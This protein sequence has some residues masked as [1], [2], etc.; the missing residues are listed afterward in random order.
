MRI[1]HG[2][3]LAQSNVSGRVGEADRGAP[4]WFHNQQWG[5]ERQWQ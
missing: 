2:Y 4:F 5:K 3:V 1:R